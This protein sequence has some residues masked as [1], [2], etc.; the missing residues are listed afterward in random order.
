[1][2]A[3]VEALAPARA[4]SKKAEAG[5]LEWLWSSTA[6]SR[7]PALVNDCRMVVSAA[8]PRIERLPAAGSNSK[9]AEIRVRP[10][11]SSR[12]GRNVRTRGRVVKDLRQKRRDQYVRAG[13]VQ[14][15]RWR[16][17]HG[18]SVA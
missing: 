17:I 6:T 13:I 4:W 7:K 18:K 16:A 10:S 2:P 11:R 1:M 14:R 8:S 5:S 15:L 9:L 3:S 12:R